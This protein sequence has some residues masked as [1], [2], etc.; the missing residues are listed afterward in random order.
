MVSAAHRRQRDTEH[1]EEA[2]GGDMAPG[3][4]REDRPGFVVTDTLIGADKTHSGRG[5]RVERPSF[6]TGASKI[7]A[8]ASAEVLG[9]GYDLG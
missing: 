7:G 4:D 6:A 8:L 9:R 3:V 2:D 1:A 5:E